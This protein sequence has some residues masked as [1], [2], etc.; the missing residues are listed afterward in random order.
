MV[1]IQRFH[2]CSPG[3]ISGWRGLRGRLRSHIKLLHITAKNFKNKTP[4]LEHEEETMG[5]R[6]DESREGSGGETCRVAGTELGRPGLGGGGEE[7]GCPRPA[8]LG[9]LP[10]AQ[11]S[12]WACV[13]GSWQSRHDRCLSL[14]LVLPASWQVVGGYFL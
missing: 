10:W 4:G 1:R 5:L 3:A 11:W 2:R 7:K 9:P 6:G 13:T 8:L 12:S 14:F